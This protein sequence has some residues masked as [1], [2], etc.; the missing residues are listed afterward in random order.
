MIK[1]DA[2]A[3]QRWGPRLSPPAL[4][5]LPWAGIHVFRR[6]RHTAIPDTGLCLV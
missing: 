1:P 6:V 4:G 5:G 2:L 3:G